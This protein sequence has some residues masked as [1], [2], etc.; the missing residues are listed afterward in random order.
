MSGRLFTLVLISER[1][2]D[3]HLNRGDLYVRL[4]SKIVELGYALSLED[5]GFSFFELLWSNDSSPGDVEDTTV[6]HVYC[7]LRYAGVIDFGA[8]SV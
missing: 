4:F 7:W 6:Q 8:L 1:A 5:K 2:A 3:C